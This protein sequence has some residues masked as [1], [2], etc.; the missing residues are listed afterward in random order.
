MLK[1]AGV[2]ILNIENLTKPIKKKGNILKNIKH[3]GFKKTLSQKQKKKRKLNKNNIQQRDK[4][5]GYSIKYKYGIS[6]D[7]YNKKL[8][9][10]NYKC[11]I[12]GREQKN[13]TK[14]ILKIDHNHKTGKIRGL[15]CFYCNIAVGHFEDNIVSLK[16]AIK[17]LKHYEV[18]DN[19]KNTFNTAASQ[20]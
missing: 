7:D 8:I 14:R 15:L 9:S 13:K 6:L 20:C 19:T 4:E 17:Y 1:D 3:G 5:F 10:Q 16:K 2:V 11:A 12:C 18:S